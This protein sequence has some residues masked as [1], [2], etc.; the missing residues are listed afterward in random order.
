MSFICELCGNPQPNRTQPVR[1][2]TESRERIYPE[3]RDE[4]D[5]SIVLIEES[6]GWEIVKEVDACKE[7]AQ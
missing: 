2:V 4:K 5:P 3:V 1:I 7:C 6:Q